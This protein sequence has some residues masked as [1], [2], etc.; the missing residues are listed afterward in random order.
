MASKIALMIDAENISHIHLPRILEEVSPLG[1][2][3]LRAVYG[4]W[5][6]PSLQKWK[7]IAEQ[8]KFNIRHQANS[9]GTKNS[10]DMK[11]IMDSMEVLF[12]TQVDTF[13]LVT[14]DAD[15]VA[16]CDKL[17]EAKRRI[18][19]VG[20]RSAA[21]A[22]I[23]A[24]DQFIF[25]GQGDA[26]PQP[27]ISSLVQPGTQPLSPL[28]V[29]PVTQPQTPPPAASNGAT[30]PPAAQHA[31]NGPA[32]RKLVKKAFAQVPQDSGGWVSLS[33]LGTA[34][35]ETEGFSTD[36]FGYSNLSKLLADMPD[37]VELQIMNGASAARLKN[38][39][40]AKP[41]PLTKLQMLIAE[42][43]S[44]STPDAAGWVAMSA[45]GMVLRQTKGFPANYDGHSNLSKL[46]QT[47]PEFVETKSKGTVMFAR[48]RNGTVNPK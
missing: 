9:S 42:A 45:L 18:V 35:R 22:L 36:Y 23:R 24:C 12:R 11:L 20:Y 30:K 44:N 46:L 19:G 16:L 38:R 28:P 7:E 13:C 29:Q 15:Y 39:A 4:N 2:I 21:E 31:V 40:V 1:S 47:M 8:H 5:N 25:V 14:N 6:Q 41:Q 17:R 43:F 10:S 26:P 32:V 48:L 34:L 27:L 33:A 37:Y 3:A